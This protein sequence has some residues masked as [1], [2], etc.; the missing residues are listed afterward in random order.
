MAVIPKEAEQAQAEQPEVEPKQERKDLGGGS[1]AGNLTADPELRY[2]PSGRAVCRMRVAVT[3]RIKDDKSGQWKDGQAQF[4]DVTAWGQLGENCAEHLARGQRIVADGQWESR[5]WEGKDGTVQE[6]IGL[7]ARDLGP[8][9]L[10]V[11][12]R[13]IKAERRRQT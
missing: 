2:T 1:L 6:S 3:P 13:V 12:A 4:F 7:V 10:F 9:M 8:S 11:G 5:T